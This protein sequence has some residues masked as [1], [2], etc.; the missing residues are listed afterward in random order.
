MAEDENKIDVTLTINRE[1]RTAAVEP[2]EFLIDTLRR[3]LD[4]RSVRRVCDLGVCGACAVLV[5]GDAVNACAVLTALVDGQEVV[6]SEGLV[7]DE[8]PNEVQQAFVDNG[9]FQCSYCIPGMVMVVQG[10]MNR[11]AT[12]SFQQVMTD[13]DG[14]LCRCGSYPQIEDAVRSLTDS[15]G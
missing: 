4:L 13:L 2:S 11:N 8:G 9:A 14:N 7:S 3:E 12:P 1:K 5:N 10:C 6:T 15:R